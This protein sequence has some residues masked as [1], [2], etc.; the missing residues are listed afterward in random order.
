M[1]DM[2]LNIPL[3]YLS[4]LSYFSEEY[5]GLFDIC[6]TDYNIYSLQT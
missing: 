1:F 5:S 3:D 4:F 6:K 2:V